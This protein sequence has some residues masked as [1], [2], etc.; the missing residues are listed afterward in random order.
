MTRD[1]PVASG[2]VDA[3]GPSLATFFPRFFFVDKLTKELGWNP[4]I[5]WQE[6]GLVLR[7][8]KG[9]LQKTHQ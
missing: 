2:P 1:V 3:R 9:S 8:G 7:G 6:L 5:T 4:N